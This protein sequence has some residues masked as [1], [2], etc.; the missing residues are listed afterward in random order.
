MV[1]AG[2]GALRLPSPVVPHMAELPE[3]TTLVLLLFA[4]LALVLL[5]SV[6]AGRVRDEVVEAERRAFL[7][8]GARTAGASR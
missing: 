6:F 1:S 5:P 7:P 3:G 8:E 2:I 4:S